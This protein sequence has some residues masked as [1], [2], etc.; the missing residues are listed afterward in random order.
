[1]VTQAAQIDVTPAMAL[2]YSQGA[3]R[4]GTYRFIA[5]NKQACSLSQ[6]GGIISSLKVAQRKHNTEKWPGKEQLGP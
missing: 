5:N 6:Q 2:P 4:L 3:L 1:M